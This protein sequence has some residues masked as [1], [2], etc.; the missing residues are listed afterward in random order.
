MSSLTD[1]QTEIEM[2][3]FWFLRRFKRNNMQTDHCYKQSKDKR[4]TLLNIID[5]AAQVV[6]YN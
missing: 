3:L 2:N 1:K 4:L 6:Q 5:S